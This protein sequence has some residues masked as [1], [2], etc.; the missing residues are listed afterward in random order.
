MFSRERWVAAAKQARD[1][2]GVQMTTEPENIQKNTMSL[3]PPL[4]ALQLL[5]DRKL[6]PGALML[7]FGSGDAD[8]LVQFVADPDFSALTAG[9]PCLIQTSE[10][11]RLSSNA[12]QALQSAGCQLVADTTIFQ[13]DGH[14]KPLPPADMTWL[15][16]DWYMAP[17]AKATGS[18]AVSRTLAL[19]LVQ[20]VT[21]DADTREIEDIFRR[22][23]T[24]SYHL[25]RLVN[26][27]TMG[28][29]KR[30]TSFAQAILILG[31][32]QLKRWLNLMLFSARKDDPRA[33]MLLAKVA[34]RARSME[35]LARAV[36]CDK[37]GQE[38]AF[39]AGMFSL[40]GI[41]F[42][43]PLAEV[44]KPL[45]VSESLENAVLRR[46]DDLGRLLQTVEAAERADTAGL[47]EYLAAIQLPANEFNRIN[48]EAHQWMLAITRNDP[49]SAHA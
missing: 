46:E 5:A 49:D 48:L 34:V 38:Q 36:G 45:Q 6:N 39:M 15:R 18:Q 3:S 26:S 47:S 1:Y 9:M 14:E 33:A 7:A 37:A 8:T 25:L 42:G 24:L 23:P 30:I 17:P 12:R 32:A 13:T 19:K 20:L 43:L 2:A 31:R 21:G 27:L 4:L 40:L 44:L 35:L 16:G 11:D 10:A 29:G 22:D 41:L 28:T